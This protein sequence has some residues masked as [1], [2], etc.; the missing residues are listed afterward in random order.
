ML[1]NDEPRAIRNHENWFPASEFP[2]IAYTAMNVTDSDQREQ[3]SFEL[4]Y[5]EGDVIDVREYTADREHIVGALTLTPMERRLLR[6]WLDYVDE[7]SAGIDAS[8]YP[9]GSSIEFDRVDGSVLVSITRLH[10]S[11]EAITLDPNRC[12]MLSAFLANIRTGFRLTT[13]YEEHDYRPNLPQDSDDGTNTQN[14][15]YA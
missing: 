14:A 3:H 12:N 8:H 5:Y 2:M 10:T 9:P 7:L 4:R 1:G 13:R 15:R 11:D 6:D